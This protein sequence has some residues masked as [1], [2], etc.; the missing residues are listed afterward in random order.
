MSAEPTCAGPS[1]RLRPVRRPDVRGPGRAPDPA[2]LTVARLSSAPWVGWGRAVGRGCR[3]SAYGAWLGG[4]ERKGL[5]N[6][7]RRKAKPHPRWTRVAAGHIQLDITGEPGQAW[8]GARRATV[9]MPQLARCRTDGAT[10]QTTS[11]EERQSTFSA[12]QVRLGARI[13]AGVAA[14][15]GLRIAWDW[16]AGRASAIVFFAAA[17]LLAVGSTVL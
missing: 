12:R 13:A 15:A 10:M 17:A 5:R 2:V 14:L 3:G 7:L 8:R 16:Q 4:L 6:C 9:P 1:R 11:P